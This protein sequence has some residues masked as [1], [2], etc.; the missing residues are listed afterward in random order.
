MSGEPAG[1]SQVMAA[2]ISQHIKSY[3]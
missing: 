2:A 1:C 3:F